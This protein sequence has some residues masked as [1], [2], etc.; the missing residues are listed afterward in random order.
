M[1]KWLLILLMLWALPTQAQLQAQVPKEDTSTPT[2]V[3][4]GGVS[5]DA[6]VLLK[7]GCSNKYGKSGIRLGMS[8]KISFVY[9]H[10]PAAEAGIAPGDVVLAVN[11][12]NGT[13]GLT[14]NAGEYIEV[15]YM[16]NGTVRT[17]IW[18]RRVLGQIYDDRDGKIDYES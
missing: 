13:E 3:L 6:T 16:H 9:N 10:S 4:T 11:G 18:I 14:G 1:I 5:E 12:K 2:P 15:K 8:G 7:G 17:V